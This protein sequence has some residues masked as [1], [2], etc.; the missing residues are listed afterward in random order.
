MED[1]NKD[2]VG[3]DCTN[4]FTTA[5]QVARFEDPF[6]RSYRMRSTSN[7]I[8][9]R[10]ELVKYFEPVSEWVYNS[11]C[12]YTKIFGLILIDYGWN[13]LKWFDM[14][15]ALSADSCDD[16][17]SRRKTKSPIMNSIILQIGQEVKTLLLSKL[18]ISMPAELNWIP[19]KWILLHRKASRLD[20]VLYVGTCMMHFVNFG[21]SQIF[22]H[23]RIGRAFAF[24]TLTDLKTKLKADAEQSEHWY[25]HRGK[26]EHFKP[27]L[28]VVL[29][30]KRYLQMF[31]IVESN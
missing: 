10:T 25:A 20:P 23:M 2:G 14:K 31:A 27:I 8:S 18:D 28:H 30:L 21:T 3:I 5:S 11:L 1:V 9:R 17:S 24:R 16:W 6:L 7:K 15:R 19:K 12:F 22:G 4:I 29:P 26:L 13:I